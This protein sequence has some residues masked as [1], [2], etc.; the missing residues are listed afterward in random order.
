MWLTILTFTLEIFVQ[1]IHSQRILTLL[2]NRPLEIQLWL[3]FRWVSGL[4][5]QCHFISFY[6]DET[7]TW[8]LQ[9]PSSFPVPSL[10]DIIFSNIAQIDKRFFCVY[11]TVQNAPW[12]AGPKAPRHRRHSWFGATWSLSCRAQ[13]MV[14]WEFLEVKIWGCPTHTTAHPWLS[15][16]D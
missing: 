15:L 7:V 11:L 1:G 4:L 3:F 12:N 13:G 5:C 16:E 9:I 14:W 10:S 2:W 6:H 8:N